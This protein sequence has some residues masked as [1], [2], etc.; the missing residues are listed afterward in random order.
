VD[1][2]NEIEL[3]RIIRSFMLLKLVLSLSG[4]VMDVS[5]AFITPPTDRELDELRSAAEWFKHEYQL[6][7]H[8]PNVIDNRRRGI[9]FST[10]FREHHIGF[11]TA[12]FFFFWGGGS[13]NPSSFASLDWNSFHLEN[14][15]K[16]QFII[17]PFF[18]EYMPLDRPNGKILTQ[19]VKHERILHEMGMAKLCPLKIVSRLDLR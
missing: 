8:S 15:N 1:N 11:V 3:Y 2:L 7:L 19:K 9:S 6:L 4:F 5:Q 16:Y 13:S 10:L 14:R 18:E 12:R 17:S